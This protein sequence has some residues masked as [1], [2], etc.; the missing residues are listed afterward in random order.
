MKKVF[1]ILALASIASIVPSCTSSS[2]DTSATG[3]DSTAVA[4]SIANAVE[5]AT[6]AD[7]NKTASVTTSTVV[8]PTANVASV[9][10]VAA[11]KK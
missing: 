4:A 1:L 6:K 3:T 11:P 2:T 8:V 5:Q 10:T 7:T 9:S